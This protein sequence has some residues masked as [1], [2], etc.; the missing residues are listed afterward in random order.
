MKV[1]WFSNTPAN[2]DEYLNYDLKGSGGWLKSLDL[3][4][5]QHVELH[6]VYYGNEDASF[7]YKATYYHQIK[8]NSSIIFKV[9][10][11][12]F[13]YNKNEK[14]FEKYHKIINETEPDIIH[15]HGTESDF[16]G[17]IAQTNIPVLVSI[18]GNVT[19]LFHKFFSGF[20]RTYLH[21]TNR[22]TASLKDLLFPK[23]FLF[24]YRLFKRLKKGEQQN[25]KH[26]KNLVG[27]T[28]WDERITRIMAPE[29]NYYHGDE[30]LRESFYNAKWMPNNNS[31]IIIHSTNGDFFSKGFETLC[32]ALNELNQIGINCELHVAGIAADNLIVKLAKKKLKHNF[33]SRGLVLMGALNEKS[34]IES[35][36]HA[37]IFIM[38]SHIENS[39][40][41][42]CE[43]M[44]LGMPCISTFAG[45]AGS[46][47]KDGEDGILVQD[48]DPWAMAGAI[49]ELANNKEKAIQ[50]GT[51]ARE[52]ALK[53][54]DKN[55]IV[56]ELIAT[57]N[58][59]I[60]ESR[61]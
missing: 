60:F 61:K 5:Q 37:D 36:L 22:N 23:K 24:D 11:R 10:N 46:L 41:S 34:L 4:L 54:H 48:G 1:L 18:Q 3:S 19:V 15:I 25:F 43:A 58:D 49:L 51:T 57:Y 39:P 28:L 2:A 30:I 6:I 47:L 52:S 44:L 45:G 16:A 38:A 33:P 13:N 17:I 56:A 27:R 32:Q 9:L 55:K 20:D 29:S 26:I 53:R 7:K 50:Y 35:L 40:N 8:K 31:K 14:K 59:V 21:T 42:L 12:L